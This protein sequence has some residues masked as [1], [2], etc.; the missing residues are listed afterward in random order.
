[1]TLKIADTNFRP[2]SQIFAA[3]CAKRHRLE[4]EKLWDMVWILPTGL[5]VKTS[6]SSVWCT[7]ASNDAVL[8]KPRAHHIF[9][10]QAFEAFYKDQR[11]STFCTLQLHGKPS[12]KIFK[13]WIV[14]ILKVDLEAILL[15][16]SRQM[17][18]LDFTLFFR[19]PCGRQKSPLRCGRLRVSIRFVLRVL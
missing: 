12:L 16:H 11:A 10:T 9:E 5:G 18:V 15:L 1:M 4:N 14:A 3:G 2:L 13:K 19:S 17:T 8:G 6:N 7:V